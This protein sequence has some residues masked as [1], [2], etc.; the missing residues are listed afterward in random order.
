LNVVWFDLSFSLNIVIQVSKI[1]TVVWLITFFLNYLGV[2]S[3]YHDGAV[4]SGVLAEFFLGLIHFVLIEFSDIIVD[5]IIFVI[6]NID[7]L[8]WIRF[9]SKVSIHE[10]FSLATFNSN[11]IT[12]RSSH[13]SVSN[14]DGGCIF[15]SLSVKTLAFFEATALHVVAFAVIIKVHEDT[16]FFFR[17]DFLFFLGVIF[18]NQELNC[19]IDGCFR[20]ET[21]GFVSSLSKFLNFIIKCSIFGEF[22]ITLVGND[23][24]ESGSSLLVRS[25]TNFQSLLFLNLNSLIVFWTPA[26]FLGL[27]NN[28]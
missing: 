18:L 25:W 22:L 13:F 9:S 11:L 6:D 4:I 24:D 20:L 8:I 21:F 3:S 5:R 10:C 7:K 12:F 23:F 17:W 2:S 26:D 28:L 15:L 19:G 1:L 14:E 27:I 16:P